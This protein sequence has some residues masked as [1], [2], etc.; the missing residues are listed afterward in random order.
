MDAKLLRDMDKYIRKNIQN[1]EIIV[2]EWLAYGVPDGADMLDLCEIA[3]DLH[4][5]ADVLESFARC[6]LENEKN[7]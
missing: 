7:G 6:V 5:T 4:L 3:N 1:E 2:E